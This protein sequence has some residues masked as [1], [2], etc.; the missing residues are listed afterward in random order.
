MMSGDNGILMNLESAVVPSRLAYCEHLSVIEHA[1]IEVFSYT[2]IFA[3][4]GL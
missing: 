2:R 3:A 1:L 4:A